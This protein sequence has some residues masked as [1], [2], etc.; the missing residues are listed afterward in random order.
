MV[1]RCEEVFFFYWETNVPNIFSYDTE[2]MVYGFF[3][4][5]FCSFF[6]CCVC[7]YLNAIPKTSLTVFSTEM[8]RLIDMFVRALLLLFIVFLSFLD[9]VVTIYLD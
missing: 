1:I 9:W 3:I 6:V 5:G 4:F 8:H 2:M 7:I